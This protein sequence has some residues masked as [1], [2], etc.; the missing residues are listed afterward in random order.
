MSP[1]D[2]LWRQ[3]LSKARTSSGLHGKADYVG[4]GVD[5]IVGEQ[6]P[7]PLLAWA[8]AGWPLS[9]APCWLQD[10]GEHSAGELALDSRGTWVSWLHP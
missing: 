3:H 2:P 6:T 9:P 8:Q 1:P 4:G 10:S 7:T 5:M